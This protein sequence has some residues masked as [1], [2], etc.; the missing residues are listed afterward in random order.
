[1]EVLLITAGLIV[2]VVGLAGAILPVIPGPPLSFAGILLLHL[3][4]RVQYSVY[5]LVITGIV[6][7]LITV[8]DYVIPA[9]FTKK[10]K[11]SDASTKGTILGTIIGLFIV[12]PLGILI[13]PILG[14]FVG[15]LIISGS[16]DK[17]FKSAFAGFL[18]L[19]SGM[20]L[21]MAFGLWALLYGIL[22]IL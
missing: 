1:M 8:L 13:F 6:A 11:A 20:L 18:G 22:S 2:L 9:Y 3:S 17:A 15:E 21:K 12:P 10:M 7:V 19:I 5:L 16:I 14:A 4:T